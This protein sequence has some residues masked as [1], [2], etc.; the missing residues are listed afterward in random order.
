M[1]GKHTDDSS[2]IGTCPGPNVAYE[3]EDALALFTIEDF[4]R[5]TPV[6]EE[7]TCVTVKFLHDMDDDEGCSD[8][9][10]GLLYYGDFDSNKMATNFVGYGDPWVE[11]EFS[12]TIPAGEY[13][14][15][16]AQSYF[17]NAEDDEGSPCYMEFSITWDGSC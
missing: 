5:V 3:T 9:F 6:F 2:R 10:L 16:V 17:T 12:A 14:S 11:L 1:L 15:L 4:G 7:D 13:A 8:L